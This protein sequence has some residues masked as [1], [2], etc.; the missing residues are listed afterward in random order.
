MPYALPG[1]GDNEL[2]LI[3]A[4]L[5]QGA[6]VAPK[7]ALSAADGQQIAAW[8]A[9][10]NQPSAKRQLVSRYI[11]EHLFIGHIHFQRRADG[12]FFRLVRSATPPGRPVAEIPSV[13]PYDAP[14][15]ARVYYRLRPVAESIADKTHF[16]YELSPARMQ[17]YRELFLAPDYTVTELPGYTHELAANPFKTF[18]AIPVTARYQFLLDDAEFFVS[19]FIKGPV[20]RGQTA[21]NVIQDRFWVAFIKP[22]L[23]FVEQGAKFLAEHSDDLALP[24]AEGDRIGL[25]GWRGYDDLGREY[26]R[27]KENFLK[28]AFLGDAGGVSLDYL[29]DGGGA[30]GNAA[31]TVFR[32]FDSATVV[33][34]LLGDTP[35]TAWIVDYPI[36]ERLH[37]L[38]VAGFNVYGTVAHQ[39]ATRK[40]MDYLRI[41]AENNFL[42]F[43]P[44]AQ[45]Q[46]MHDD[47]Y[48]GIGPALAGL[49]EAPLFSIEQET[50]V[51]YRG[52]DYK[53]E[54]F[55]QLRAKLGAAGGVPDNINRCELPPC[56]SE[57]VSAARRD[58]DAAMRVMAALQGRV[59]GVLPEMSLLRVETGRSGEDLIYTL[60]VDKALSN[61][62]FI[63]AEDLR[64]LP[65]QDRLTVV[66]G[67]LGSYPNFFFSV[68][69][70]QL[71]GFIDALK[72]I[73]GEAD[74]DRFYGKYGIRR[75]DPRFWQYSDWF[76]EKY[77]REKGV[78]AGIFDLNRY[79]NL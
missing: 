14:Q 33:Q 38:L 47:W 15:T 21:L 18:S 48:Q 12:E 67:F 60:L 77:Q 19:G 1:L 10:L 58:A 46:K 7:P 34:G 32:H 30:N 27:Q 36:F 31:L 61:I 2:A 43:M 73:R 20:C 45:R 59:L 11:Y 39:L 53:K 52:S 29:W 5:E 41:D 35:K 54:F 51:V 65:G 16:V 22:G 4:W 71:R 72:S 42:R 75:N 23:P 57:G 56:V 49:F 74:K 9:F 8:E 66:S 70:S 63:F 37:Y 24:G 13:L 69:K 76:N 28:Q 6:K 68:E 55:R 44:A 64:R 25:F 26:L 3:L 79:E 62:S 17:R 78:N 50:A 40:Y